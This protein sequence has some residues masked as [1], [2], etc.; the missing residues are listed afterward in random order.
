[1]LGREFGP[2]AGQSALVPFDFT[3]YYEPEF[4]AD[5]TRCWVDFDVGFDPA[6]LAAAKLRA[7]ELERALAAPDGR[8]LVNLDPG[9]LTL[10]NL[11]LASTKDHAH[12]VCLGSGI[13]AELT[14]VF[15]SG[16]FR[17]LPWT[18]PD[19]RTPACLE[20]LARCRSRLLAAPRAG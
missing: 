8:R 20:F 9:A 11:V 4:G 13:F 14:L 12:R 16:A 2:V 17:A 18:Y 10:H 19:Y 1:V 5:L 7:I 3:D 6:G 15:E